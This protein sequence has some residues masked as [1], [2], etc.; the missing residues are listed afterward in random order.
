M[1]NYVLITPCAYFNIHESSKLSST[2]ICPYT[3]PQGVLKQVFYQT[4]EAFRVRGQ[5]ERDEN[6]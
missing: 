6:I 5:V 4:D 2:S 3:L 1:S